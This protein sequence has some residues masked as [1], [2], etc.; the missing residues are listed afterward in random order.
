MILC[1]I[2][3]TSANFLEDKKVVSMKIDEFRNYEPK[4]KIYFINVNDSLKNKLSNNSNF[5]DLEPYFDLECD[6]VGLGIDRIACC[7]AINDG[8]IV[9]AGSAIT[10]DVMYR[11]VHLGGCIMPGL[12]FLKKAYES[13]SPRLNLTL[14]TQISI[15]TFPQNTIDAISYGTILPVVLTI[16]NMAQNKKVFFTGGDGGFFIKYFDKAVF[17][18]MAIFRGMKKLIEEKGL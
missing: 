6:Y 4:E 13:I 15:D 18:K 2:G 9:D 10:I 8:I 1:D 17:D 3:N 5:F 7:Y 14:N 11:G 12:A 16:K